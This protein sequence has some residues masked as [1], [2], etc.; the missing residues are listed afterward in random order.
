MNKAA[1][2]K[3]DWACWLPMYAS[4]FK[5]VFNLEEKSVS[6]AADAFC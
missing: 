1:L 5:K 3:I 2:G 4:S 6:P